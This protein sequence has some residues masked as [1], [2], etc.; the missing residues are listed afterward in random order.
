M[1]RK[2]VAKPTHRK[3]VDTSKTIEPIDI[4]RVTEAL[5]A[6]PGYGPLESIPQRKIQNR[7]QARLNT[8]ILRSNNLDNLRTFYENIF[9]LEFEKHTDHGPVH[10]GSQLGDLYFELYPTKNQQKQLDGIGFQVTSI[11]DILSNLEDLQ[12]HKY[13][14]RTNYGLSASITDPDG[15]LVLLTEKR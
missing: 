4:E 2:M 7:N 14:L 6:E 5:G 9:Q 15:R 12:I 13:P 1:A 11:V 3:L 10:Y 8:L